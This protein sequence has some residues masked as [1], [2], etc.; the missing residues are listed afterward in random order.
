MTPLDL[1]LISLACWYVSYVIAQL[2]GPYAAFAWLK[3]R[4][5][6][7]KCI[8]CLS[9]WIAAIWFLVYL[10]PARPLVYPFALAGAALMLHR[11]T[12]GNHI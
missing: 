9:P 6:V 4:A 8:Y 11:Y 1:L 12:G 10:T 3:A 5:S 2:D 7:F